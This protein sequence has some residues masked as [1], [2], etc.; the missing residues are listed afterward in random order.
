MSSSTAHLDSLK[1]SKTVRL[2]FFKNL[3]TTIHINLRAVHKLRNVK[4]MGREGDHHGAT[5]EP[6][7]QSIEAL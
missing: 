2:I 3:G 4:R 1:L 5:P 6:K 7:G